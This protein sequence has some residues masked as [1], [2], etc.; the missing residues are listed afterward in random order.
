ML[1][2]DY[3]ST[4]L[5]FSSPRDQRVRWLGGL[6]Y[7]RSKNDDQTLVGIDASEA[8]RTLGLQPSQ[9]QFLLIDRGG[10]IPG[11]APMASR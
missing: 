11:L 2:S 5:R 6:F 3:W 4:E 8:V 9:I 10:I 7:F 1:D